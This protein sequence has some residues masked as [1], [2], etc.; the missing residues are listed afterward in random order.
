MFRVKDDTGK[1]IRCDTL[2]EAQL[3]E[4]CWYKTGS[5]EVKIVELSQP[6]HCKKNTIGVTRFCGDC[7]K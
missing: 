5:K 3:V 1:H 2:A 6:C 4:A 7:R